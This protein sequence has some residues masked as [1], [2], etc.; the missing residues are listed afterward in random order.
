MMRGVKN[1]VST[2]GQP[3]PETHVLETLPHLRGAMIIILCHVFSNN[4]RSVQCADIP[5]M[6]DREINMLSLHERDGGL[7]G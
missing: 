4:R 7:C 3:D 2:S 1:D 5:N 6:I